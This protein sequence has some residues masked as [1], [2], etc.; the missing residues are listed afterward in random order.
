[1]KVSRRSVKATVLSTNLTLMSNRALRMIFDTAADGLPRASL[2]E[3]VPRM[4]AGTEVS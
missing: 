3:C 4:A 1:V 2:E